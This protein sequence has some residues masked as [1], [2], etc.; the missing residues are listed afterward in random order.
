MPGWELIVLD[1]FNPAYW[2][3]VVCSRQRQR[4]PLAADRVVAPA[5]RKDRANRS[6]SRARSMAGMGQLRLLIR[7]ARN[8]RF[9]KHR[10]S[11]LVVR[12]WEERAE[13]RCLPDQG[14]LDEIDRLV[15]KNGTLAPG[16]LA[17]EPDG[18]IKAN[19]LRV[20]WDY[21]EFDATESGPFPSLINRAL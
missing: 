11:A 19:S 2:P 6:G 20:P 18:F 13:V 12:L 3:L 9:R 21:I 8:D 16:S 17:H 7:P 1:N 5:T 15:G 14:H 4:F 10:T